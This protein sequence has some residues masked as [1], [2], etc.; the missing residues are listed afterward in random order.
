MDALVSDLAKIVGA[1]NILADHA[2]RQVYACAASFATA[3]EA[4]L[5][6]LACVKPSHSY[7]L[8]ALL[9]FCSERTLPLLFRGAGTGFVSPPVPYVP[10]TILIL[11]SRLNRI[12]EIDPINR[13]AHVQPGVTCAQL[14]RAAGEKG[15]FYPAMP[16]SADIATIGGNIALN[17]AGA[18]F[19]KYGPAANYLLSLDVWTT[20][21]E[22]LVC[23]AADLPAGFMP[24]LPLAQLFCGSQGCLGF[25]GDCHLR[26]LPQ[27]APVLFLIPCLDQKELANKISKILA[28]RLLP[29]F[30]DFFDPVSTAI[31][32]DGK[33]AN[34]WLLALQVEEND[35]D[36][37]CEALG[38]DISQYACAPAEFWEK[39]KTLLPA[40]RQRGPFQ[41]KNYRC[42]AD[43]LSD[44]LENLGAIVAKY[45]IQ[46]SVFGHAGIASV[47]V[48]V[49]GLND[50]LAAAAKEMAA[51][52]LLANNALTEEADLTLSRAQW[53]QKSGPV[54]KLSHSLRSLFD[55]AGLLKDRPLPGDAR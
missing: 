31:L 30:L 44:F 51:L 34:V 33:E 8:E 36:K 7:Q 3:P 35:R 52:E 18:G 20:A 12:Y 38:A 37:V 25:I 11:T 14:A 46:M 15:L 24:A 55:P 41:L 9:K 17:A 16:Y 21:G 27:T 26:L 2:S 28:S 10:D 32:A 19:L 45:Q 4:S 5:L 48:A 50:N 43:R 54:S 1:E 47:F 53:Q 13:Q 22:K 23:A 29:D 39:R 42:L 49:Q 40:L 6:P